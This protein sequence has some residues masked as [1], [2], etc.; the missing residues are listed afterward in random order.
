MDQTS[1][2][3]LHRPIDRAEDDKFG[4]LHRADAHLH[5]DLTRVDEVPG[6][7]LVVALT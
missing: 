3:V 5:V 7:G 4:G 6:V 1:S 2:M